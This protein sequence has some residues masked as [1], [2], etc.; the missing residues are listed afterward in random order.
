MEPLRKTKTTK[1]KL[2]DFIL[3]WHSTP[4]DY[5]WR[6]KYN[7]P[8]GSQRHREMNPIDMVIEYQEEELLK[9]IKQQIEREDEE[10]ELRAI[11]INRSNEVKM[12]Q[13]EIDDEFENLDLSQFNK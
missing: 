12:S 11:G 9:E 8:F 1:D 6:Q 7:V 3:E 13:T 4:V 10:K 2:N 5:W